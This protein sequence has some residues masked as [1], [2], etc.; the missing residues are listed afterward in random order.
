MSLVGTKTVREILGLFKN[1]S[2]LRVSSK[3]AMVVNL[4]SVATI[5][6]MV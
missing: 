4:G 1:V 6:A 5:C 3:D 2:R